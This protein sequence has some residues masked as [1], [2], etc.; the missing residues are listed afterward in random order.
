MGAL[1]SEPCLPGAVM[2]EVSYTLESLCDLRLAEQEAGKFVQTLPRLSRRERILARL[3]SGVG[4]GKLS[5]AGREPCTHCSA[6]PGEAFLLF[7]FPADRFPTP[8]ACKKPR[9]LEMPVSALR[10]SVDTHPFGSSRGVTIMVKDRGITV[11]C[12][13]LTISSDSSSGYCWSKPFFDVDGAEQIQTI[14][15]GSIVS[16]I[17][18]NMHTSCAIGG[19][20]TSV[21]GTFL[22]KYGSIAAT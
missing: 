21:S 22:E 15:G 13:S 8:F 14:S 1:I 7:W 2:V 17:D 3:Q 4:V 11:S 18:T 5:R 9:R 10:T 16:S 12:F 19:W 20:C 6:L